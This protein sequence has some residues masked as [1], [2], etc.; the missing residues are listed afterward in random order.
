MQKL[1]SINWQVANINAYQYQLSN[2]CFQV[3]MYTFESPLW[4]V[5]YNFKSLSGILYT[6][7]SIKQSQNCS[8]KSKNS[9]IRMDWRGIPGPRSHSRSHRRQWAWATD[10]KEGYAGHSLGCINYAAQSKSRQICRY[11]WML[12]RECASGG[13]RGASSSLLACLIMSQKYFSQ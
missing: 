7:N 12:Q 9:I 10:S 2:H 5:E 1:I 6:S 8:F 13:V 3:N 11:K 4:L